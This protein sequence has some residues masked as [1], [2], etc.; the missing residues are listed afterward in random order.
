MRGCEWLGELISWCI[1]IMNLIFRWICLTYQHTIRW[2]R[3]SS[4]PK[5]ITT[6][7]TQGPE[8]DVETCM[9][10]VGCWYFFVKLNARYLFSQTQNV[11]L[12][13]IWYFIRLSEYATFLY[14]K[15]NYITFFNHIHTF[16]F[17]FNIIH[18]I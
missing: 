3:S 12:L 13:I 11:N 9:I 18:I 15:R 4:F 10:N 8:N 2:E 16:Q 6:K 14:L 1:D 7:E 17:S 5:W